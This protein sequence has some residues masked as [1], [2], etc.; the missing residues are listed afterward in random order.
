M[1]IIMKANATP[2]QTEA[3]I[4]SVKEAGLNV[5]LS[6]GV[7]ATIIGAI[8]ETQ[9]E[10]R[11]GAE[12]DDVLDGGADRAAGGIGHELG[13]LQGRSWTYPSADWVAGIQRDLERQAKD[14]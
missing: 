6:Q 11:I 3:V 4:A 7:E 8:G 14:R 5:H 9:V 13:M 12:I 1:M 10:M 2:Q